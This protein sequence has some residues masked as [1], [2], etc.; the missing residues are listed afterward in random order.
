MDPHVSQTGLV[1]WTRYD[2]RN[3]YGEPMNGTL[4]VRLLN[5]RIKDFTPSPFDGPFIEEWAFAENDTAVVIKCRGRHGPATYHKFN[6]S[7]G[8]LVDKLGRSAT[9]ETMPEWARPIA[10]DRPEP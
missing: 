5:G 1:G 4:R 3:A 8:A 9:F 2:E 7:S 10:D 6:V